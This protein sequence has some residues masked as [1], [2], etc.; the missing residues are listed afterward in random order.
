M[1]LLNVVGAIDGTHIRIWKPSIA[2]H[3]G[4]IN[5]HK[6]HSYSVQAVVND[7]GLFVNVV[8][9]LPGA[10]HDSGI[11]SRS[12]F[13]RHAAATIPRHHF[14]LGDSGYALLPWLLSP[15]EDMDHNEPLSEEAVAFNRAHASTRSIV[16]RAFGALKSRWRKLHKMDMRKQRAVVTLI[17]CSFVLH[18][19]VEMLEH[20][21]EWP[22]VNIVFESWPA[23][24]ARAYP[25]VRA[26]SDAQR[27]EMEGERNGLAAFVFA[28]A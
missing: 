16:E 9:G 19:F 1:K 20:K 18:N 11:L 5:R 8:V 6:Y 26:M 10:S 14:I 12:A 23:V 17:R 4:Y 15:Y 22:D 7:R 21:A 3:V 27:D 25:A 28:K 24:A 2:H 13:S